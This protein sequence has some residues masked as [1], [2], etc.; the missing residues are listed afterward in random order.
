MNERID[1]WSIGKQWLRDNHR[2][3]KSKLPEVKP[4]L[5]ALLTGK[6][7]VQVIWFGHSSF[8]IRFEEKL[9]LVDPV[10]SE[11][12]SPLSFLVK[13]FQAPV[14]K[15]EELPKIDLIVISH[16]HYDHLDMKAMKFF[17]KTP[18]QFLTP[19]GVGSH[20]KKWGVNPSQII[21]KDWWES[22]QLGPI[23]L[24]ATPAQHFSGRG[25]T[26]QNTTL[27]A[28]WVLRS[29]S[30]SLYFSGDSG[31]ADH[32]KEIGEKLGPFDIAFMETGQ[33]NLAWREVHMLPEDAIQ[34][35]K[36]LKAKTYFPIHWG[37]F[38]LSLHSWFEPIIRLTQLAKE[39][40]IPL[41]TPRIGEMVTLE[42]KA[43]QPWWFEVMNQEQITIAQE[44]IAEE[45]WL[46]AEED[47]PQEVLVK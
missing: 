26:S 1:F 22:H 3:P 10:F 32:F 11:S 18:T 24:T 33:Y 37:M 27:W 21:E 23:T 35:Y 9:I 12:A 30:H 13:R 45:S 46:P 34:A 20:L 42:D 41:I 47:P 28:S 7:P 5:K 15:L 16:D 29:K 36:D 38:V 8:L 39:H 25:P 6:G 2:T 40:Q 44:N 43:F 17:A 31:Y 4:N 14:L 19:L